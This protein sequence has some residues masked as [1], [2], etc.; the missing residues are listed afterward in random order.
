MINSYSCRMVPNAEHSLAN[1]VTSV[2][3]AIRAF[4]LAVMTVC[5][6]V[7]V[8][9]VICLCLPLPYI[10]PPPLHP[11]S[12]L[13]PCMTPPSASLPHLPQL[14]HR[15]Y[16]L[17][18]WDWKRPFNL[19][20]LGVSPACAHLQSFLAQPRPTLIPMPLSYCLEL[21]PCCVMFDAQH[22]SLES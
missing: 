17:R 15:L 11:F 8:A 6:H 18:N 13:S 1:N 21:L 10:N 22:R 14:N 3:P 2:F 4:L 16:R 19:L 12:S 20:A 5:W 7:K 9:S